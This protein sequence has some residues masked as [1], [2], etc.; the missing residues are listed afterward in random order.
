MRIDC[1]AENWKSTVEYFIDPA[2]V[3]KMKSLGLRIRKMDWRERAVYLVAEDQEDM[4][5]IIA[6]I[7][8]LET[9]S[10]PNPSPARAVKT[11]VPS[12]SL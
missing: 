11:C 3:A 6:S 10:S 9:K 1:T 12:A 7:S 2:T 8:T 5:R 4:A